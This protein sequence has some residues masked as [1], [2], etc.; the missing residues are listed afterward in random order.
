[1]WILASERIDAHPPFGPARALRK[2]LQDVARDGLL[3]GRDAVLEVEDD[4]VRLAIERLGDLSLAVGRDEQPGAG[5]G[6]CGRLLEQRGARALAD[7]LV[8]LV[9]AAVRPGDDAG[10]RPRLALANR[11]AFA[12]AAKRV[13]GEHR[14]GKVSLS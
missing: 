11:D 10:V 7:E 12:F 8:A 9:E 1:M 3:R 13:A 5:L 4:R 14:I 2:F 6:H